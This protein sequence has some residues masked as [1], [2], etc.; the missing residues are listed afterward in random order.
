M[1]NTDVIRAVWSKR[2]LAGLSLLDTLKHDSPELI[3]CT[4]AMRFYCDFLQ[5]VINSG[6]TMHPPAI[7]LL[8]NGCI[9]LVFKKELLRENKIPKLTVLF[10]GNEIKYK[11][12]YTNVLLKGVIDNKGHYEKEL[13]GMVNLCLLNMS[14]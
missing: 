5:E 7:S 12:V 6:F 14:L 4:E 13:K 9:E 1:Y 2:Y 11:S 3:S 8:E 10:K